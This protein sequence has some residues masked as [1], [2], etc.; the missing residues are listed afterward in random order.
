MP[1]HG[2]CVVGQDCQRSFPEVL[3]YGKDCHLGEGPRKFQ[4]GMVTLPSQ[5]VVIISVS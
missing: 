2:R 5:L 4:V 1:Y 3:H